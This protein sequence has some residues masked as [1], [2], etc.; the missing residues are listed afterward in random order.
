MKRHLSLTPVDVNGQGRQIP[1]EDD[2][3][4][5]HKPLGRNNTFSIKSQSRC[6][7]EIDFKCD[8]Y[9]QLNCITYKC[10]NLQFNKNCER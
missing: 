1:E 10:S 7:W 5:S 3:F 2:N 4:A 9:C 8:F 6:G